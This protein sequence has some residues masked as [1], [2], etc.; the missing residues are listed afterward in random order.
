MMLHLSPVPREGHELPLTPEEPPQRAGSALV[1]EVQSGITEVS[2]GEWRQQ[3][4]SRASWQFSLGPSPEPGS[5]HLGRN[6]GLLV[7]WF[8]RGSQGFAGVILEEACLQCH[9]AGQ[10]QRATVSPPACLPCSASRSQVPAGFL[11]CGLRPSAG[12]WWLF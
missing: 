11:S 9:P 10:S 7:S 5:G 12:P 3:P 6:D 4:E 1:A 2:G 8:L